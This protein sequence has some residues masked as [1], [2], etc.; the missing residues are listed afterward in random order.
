MRIIVIETI[1]KINISK[2]YIKITYSITTKYKITRIFIK[3]ECIS[4]CI[5]SSTKLFIHFTCSK[6]IVTNQLGI[7]SILLENHQQLHHRFFELY[8][9]QDNI[10]LKRICRNNS[11][12][13]FLSFIPIK[14]R[15]KYK[16]HLLTAL[17]HI[18][19]VI[20]QQILL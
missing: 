4:I 11:V 17:S 7:S 12:T 8:I 20:S 3:M 10:L 19:E 15:I 16:K 14:N 18:S 6:P 5:K 1:I 9:Y 2:I 13:H